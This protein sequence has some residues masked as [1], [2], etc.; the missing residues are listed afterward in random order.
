MLTVDGGQSAVNL[1]S[2]IQSSSTF[3]S[4]I[5]YLSTKLNLVLLLY[6]GAAVRFSPYVSAVDMFYNITGPGCPGLE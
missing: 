2:K 5:N 3:D 6:V 4:Y 1:S